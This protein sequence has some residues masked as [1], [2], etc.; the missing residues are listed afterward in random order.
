MSWVGAVAAILV[1]AVFVVAG[2]SKLAAG[3]RWPANAADL[4][5]PR[6]LAVVVPWVELAIGASLGVQLLM[7]W[8]AV[9]AAGMLLA[10]SAVLAIRLRD[11]DRPSCACFGQWSESEIGVG[12]LARNAVLLVLAAVAAFA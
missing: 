9:A 10:F 8:P 2:A 1:G 7:P 3:E 6:P 12:H 11:V 4:G 5:V